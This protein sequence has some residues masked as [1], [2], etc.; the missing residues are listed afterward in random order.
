MEYKTE[1]IDKI[2]PLVE[3][4][5]D[6]RFQQYMKTYLELGKDKYYF[7]EEFAKYID[8]CKENKNG[9]KTISIMSFKNFLLDAPSM[10][11]LEEIWD[12]VEDPLDEFFE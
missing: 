5:G 1:S 2:N 6:K 4:M 7:F 12:K 11:E 8:T 9:Y 3:E 10:E